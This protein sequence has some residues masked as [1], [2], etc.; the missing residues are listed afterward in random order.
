MLVPDPVGGTSVVEVAVGTLE[1]CEPGVV[2]VIEVIL[3][4]KVVVEVDE[5]LELLRVEVLVLVVDVG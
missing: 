1:E 2:A 5:G 3:G 4:S